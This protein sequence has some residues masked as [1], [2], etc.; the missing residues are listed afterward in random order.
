L[1]FLRSGV[2]AAIKHTLD[3]YL[4]LEKTRRRLATVVASPAASTLRAA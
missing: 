4:A 3:P 1:Q 2:A